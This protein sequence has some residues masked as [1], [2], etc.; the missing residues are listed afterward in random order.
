MNKT[1][2]PVVV[3]NISWRDLCPWTI[4]FRSLN[5]ATSM[6]VLVMALA[7]LVLMP[8]GWLISDTVFLNDELRSDSVLAR[9][10]DD[11]QKPYKRVFLATDPEENSINLLGARLS[12]PRMVFTQIVEPFR[13]LFSLPTYATALD[14]SSSG[15]S[16]WSVR[17]FF[18]LLGGCVWTIFL[19]SFAGVAICRTCLLKLTRNEPVGLDDAFE[20]SL[21]KT[22][23]VAG[24]VS[25][26][27]LAIGAMCIPA[28]C[29]GLLMGLD[30]G[31]L[32]VGLLWFVV[33]A[34]GLVMALLLLGLMFGWPLMVAS[35][36]CEGQNSFDAM[37]RSYAYVMQRP[38]NFVLYLLVSM[39]F[40]GFCWY[41]VANVADGA[42]GLGYWSTSFGTRLVGG[43]TERMDVI[44]S[45]AP[46]M[47]LE[48]GNPIVLEPS[49]PLA[50][51]QAMIRM[52]TWLGRT[53]AAAFIYGLFWCMM[54]AV[55]LLLR[56]DVDDTEMDEIFMVDERRTY[57]LPPLKTDDKGI[58]VVQKPEPVEESEDEDKKTEDE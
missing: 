52:W 51:G 25:A 56:K 28:F 42:I 43:D 37:T 6:T 7:A 44:R 4:I 45:I 12:G 46:P 30:L 23:T 5:S 10:I 9:L 33:L 49:S 21:D 32:L 34:L 8:V 29:L 16:R 2:Q 18:Y 19:W 26:P 47:G 13:Q 38:L 40:G 41:V 14:G 36:A 35:V 22:L 31:V 1:D 24:A 39:V 53:T 58:P 3:S 57:E 50:G 48:D 54:S 20:F 55:Y 27:L 11:N 17:A 15:S